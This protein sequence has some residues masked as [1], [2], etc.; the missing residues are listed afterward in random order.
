MEA[1]DIL[2]HVITRASRNE[3]LVENPGYLRIKLTASPVKGRANA[4][5]IKFLAKKFDVSKS[6]VE[7]LKGLT[8]HQKL[9]R[10]YK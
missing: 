10:I 3:V 8:S 7:I 4:E 1:H 6:S 9:V 5:L 2:V